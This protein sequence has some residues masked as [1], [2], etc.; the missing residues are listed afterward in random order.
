METK[1]PR[2]QSKSVL[3]MLT[4]FHC[5]ECGENFNSGEGFSFLRW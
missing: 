5:P 4:G 3:S 1:C 2:C